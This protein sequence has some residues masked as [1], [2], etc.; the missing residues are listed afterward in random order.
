MIPS[1]PR[2]LFI[3][4]DPAL[5]NVL[6]DHCVTAGFSVVENEAETDIAVID[7][8]GAM[9]VETCLNLRKQGVA[10]VALGGGLDCC[11]DG[12]VA[13][14][15]RLGVLASV[16]KKALEQRPII[17][18]MIGPWRFDSMARHLED[19]SGHRVR[20]TDKESTILAVLRQAGGVVS[21]EKLL[22]EVW[23]YTAAITTHTLETHIYR[24][25][26]KIEAD[27]GNAALLLTEGGGYRLI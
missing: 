2:L 27:P 22:A 15:V 8:E 24:L 20:L 16:L 7:S 23:G 11:V 9:A 12:I 13:K 1:P 3:V 4:D 6:A 18:P 21:R 14:P 5:R 25:R 26:R 19:A 10:V 17:D